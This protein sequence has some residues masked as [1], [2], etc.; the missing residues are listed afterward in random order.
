MSWPRWCGAVASDM[1]AIA[2][3]RY[4]RTVG[5]LYRSRRGRQQSVNLMM[6]SSGMAYWYRRYGGRELGFP[7]AEEEAKTQRRGVW[8]DRR[9]GQTA[10]LGLSV[11]TA[12]AAATA[13]PPR[14]VAG[15]PGGAGGD[16]GD[17]GRARFLAWMDRMKGGYPL[18]SPL[19]QGADRGMYGCFAGG[20]H[21]HPSPL[22]SRERGHCGSY[23]P[24]SA[25]KGRGGLA[26]AFSKSSGL[27][28]W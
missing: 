17:T 2:I 8:K 19:P 23:L 24:L 10:S 21:P 15:V 16:N 27:R 12:S 9:S 13:I 26:R 14:A 11:G 5:L 4:G 6:V 3:D 1:E 7:E 22:P 25:H 28:S 20:F 18:P